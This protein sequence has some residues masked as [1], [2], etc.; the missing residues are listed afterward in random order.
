MYTRKRLIHTVWSYNETRGIAAKSLSSTDT[1]QAIFASWRQKKFLKMKIKSS[2]H[3]KSP[4][5]T[6]VTTEN[7][8]PTLSMPLDSLPTFPKDPEW[9]TAHITR[10]PSTDE[11]KTTLQ[12]RRLAGV[13]ET[14]HPISIDCLELTRVKR[15]TA[16]TFEAS[17]PAQHALAL[18]QRAPSLQK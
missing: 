15:L 12:N 18:F 3:W 14:W 7:D 4:V 10:D 13:G 1:L 8:R 16:S 9:N 11:P 5:K 6:T 17:Y 2:F